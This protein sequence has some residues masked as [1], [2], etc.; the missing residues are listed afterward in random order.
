MFLECLECKGLIMGNSDLDF[1]T[2]TVPVR[3]ISGHALNRAVHLRFSVHFYT[4]MYIYG[5]AN[6]R[7]IENV[8]VKAQI[9]ARS[10]SLPLPLHIRP[11][12]KS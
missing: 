9:S 12:K 7:T 11:I 3:L 8:C 6:H 4:A 10:L 1:N 5:F 2:R